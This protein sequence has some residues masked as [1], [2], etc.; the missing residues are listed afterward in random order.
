MRGQVI[1]PRKPN[2]VWL[3]SIEDIKHIPSARNMS[4]IRHNYV[5]IIGRC[6]YI[7]EVLENPKFDCFGESSQLIGSEYWLEFA[8][9]GSFCN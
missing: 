8:H 9:S 7:S 3:G 2:R 6:E 1:C 5:K 4:I